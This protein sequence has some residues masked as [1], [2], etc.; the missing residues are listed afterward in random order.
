MACIIITIIL[1]IS[2]DE[3]ACLVYL[4]PVKQAL[5]LFAELL[6]KVNAGGRGGG[7]GW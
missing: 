1:L 5:N 4:G 3:S 7:G 2:D 6:R